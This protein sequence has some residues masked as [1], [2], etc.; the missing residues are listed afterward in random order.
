MKIP[1]V[2]KGCTYQIIAVTGQVVRLGIINLSTSNLSLK[3]LSNGVYFLQ[4]TSE[5]IT[6]V[7]GIVKQ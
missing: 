1:L 2:E 6:K 3:G 4:L 5:K 7:I